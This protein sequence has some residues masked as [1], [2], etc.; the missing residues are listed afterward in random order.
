MLVLS[1]HG[2]SLT[3]HWVSAPLHAAAAAATITDATVAQNSPASPDS[4]CKTASSQTTC[5]APH[6]LK[7]NLGSNLNNTTRAMLSNTRCN[8]MQKT[9]QHLQRSLE[10]CTVHT[11][12]CNAPQASHK[13]SHFAQTAKDSGGWYLCPGAS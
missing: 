5:T 10:H 11:D 9:E 1:S 6:I 12:K 3:L 4:Q 8:G 7:F 2:H 13:Q